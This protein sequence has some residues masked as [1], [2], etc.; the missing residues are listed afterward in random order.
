MTVDR[1]QL[2]VVHGVIGEVRHGVPAALGQ[3]PSVGGDMNPRAETWAGVADDNL[4]VPV[5][6][7]GS[8]LELK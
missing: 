7:R 8:Q 6:V 3:G 2:D 1:H 5:L 4:L